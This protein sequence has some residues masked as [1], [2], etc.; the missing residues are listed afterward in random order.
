[1]EID[2]YSFHMN[3]QVLNLKEDDLLSYLNVQYLNLC[4]VVS[5][6]LKKI[7]FDFINLSCIIILCYKLTAH[8][9]PVWHQFPI[10]AIDNLIY[11]MVHVHCIFIAKILATC[12]LQ[13]LE[14]KK[15]HPECKLN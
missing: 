4:F 5:R 13:W 6:G 15:I 1:M 9:G 8:V 12:M 14:N 10:P 2:V 7:M 11:L 3:V